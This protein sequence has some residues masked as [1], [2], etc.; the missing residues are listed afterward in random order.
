MQLRNAQVQHA[1]MGALQEDPEF[2]YLAD[3]ATAVSA[4]IA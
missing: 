1:V 2:R 3:A 4:H